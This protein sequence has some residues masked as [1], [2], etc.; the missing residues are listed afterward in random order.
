MATPRNIS[1]ILDGFTLGEL[2]SESTNAKCYRAIQNYSRKPYIVKI[3]SLPPSSAQL[4]SLLLSGAFSGPNEVN[5]YYKEKA[6]DILR[7]V[8]VLRHMATIGGFIDYDCVQVVPAEDG[9]GYE[10]YLLCPFRQSLPPLLQQQ[11]MTHMDAV[12]MALDLCAAL[13][14]C[15]RSGYCYAN[16]T[17]GNIFRQGSHYHIG[18]LGFLPLYEIGHT[19]LP[20]Q[21]RS[22][23]TAPELMDGTQ[24]INDTADVYSLGLI[25]YQV[26]SGGT[27]PGNDAVFGRLF[28]P[29]KYADYE[30]AEIILRASAPDPSI[31]WKGPEQMGRALMLYTQRNGMRDEPLVPAIQE[32]PAGVST[33]DF[34]PEKPI[35]EAELSDAAHVEAAFRATPRRKSTTKAR[36]K[37]SWSTIKL[38]TNGKKMS[39][40]IWLAI[41]ILS[42]LLI[43]ELIISII[44]FL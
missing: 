24:P 18:D 31:R 23:Y 41:G 44:I 26:F 8:Q 32:A 14:V 35:E 43:L 36:R 37:W 6:R 29:P 25:L 28:L 10:V 34:L 7:N 22:S 42:A 4:D 1:P 12:N 13:T 27:L 38:R 15:R 21:Y 9:K 17:P 19:P 30:M 5:T 11:S 2:I 3:I 20:E 33:E 39:K 16:L 40:K